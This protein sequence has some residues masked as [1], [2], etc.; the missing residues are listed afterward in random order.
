MQRCNYLNDT[1]ESK[2]HAM[3]HINEAS[4]IWAPLLTEPG[5]ANIRQRDISSPLRNLIKDPD[6]FFAALYGIK[7]V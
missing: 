3:S 5:A 4:T 7:K 1:H 2:T 6:R